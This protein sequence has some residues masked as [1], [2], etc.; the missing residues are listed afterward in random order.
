VWGDSRF[1]TS[2]YNW[3]KP[4]VFGHYELAEP[5]ITPTKI[6][7]DT[8]AYRTGILTAMDIVERRIIQ[9]TR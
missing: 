6:G 5:L 1:L 7:L 4:V 9:A 8:A 3:G 2:S